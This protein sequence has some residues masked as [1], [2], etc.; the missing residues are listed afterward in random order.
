MASERSEA[1]ILLDR[2]LRERSEFVSGQIKKLNAANYHWELH[3][4]FRKKKNFE[5]KG[6]FLD[7]D[8]SWDWNY[9]NM[10][11]SPEEG[12]I[13][14][15]KDGATI[16]VPLNYGLDTESRLELLERKVRDAIQAT[17]AASVSP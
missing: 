11:L 8:G 3:E 6:L 7:S 13:Y 17:T 2:Q 5:G 16:P 4:E 1:R 9:D 12:L 15:R 10:I 14:V